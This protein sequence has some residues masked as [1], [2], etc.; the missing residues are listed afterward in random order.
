MP[1][2]AIIISP[3]RKEENT[4]DVN[5]MLSSMRHEPFYKSDTYV[6]AALGFYAGWLVHPGSYSD[7]LPACS[8]DGNLLLFFYGEHLGESE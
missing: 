2:L 8:D 3:T 4:R 6:N 1:G 7:C 5:R